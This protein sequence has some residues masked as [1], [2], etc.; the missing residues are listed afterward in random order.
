MEKSIILGGCQWDLKNLSDKKGHHCAAAT[1]LWFEVGHIRYRHIIGKLEG[2]VPIQVAI[3][4]AG[5]KPVGLI[6]LGV[7]VDF[8]CASQ[9]FIFF[10][11]KMPI[12]IQIMD[13]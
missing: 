4:G 5:T 6:F 8:L 1:S 10:F 12:M 13:I 3:H 11:E 9:K 2:I 7:F